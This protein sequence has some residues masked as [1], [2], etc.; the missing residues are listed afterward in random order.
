MLQ[1]EDLKKILNQII[2]SR[3]GRDLEDILKD[4]LEYPLYAITVIGRFYFAEYLYNLIKF[5]KAIDKDSLDLWVKYFTPT[6]FMLGNPIRVAER[7]D[8]ITMYNAKN[9]CFLGPKP[10][11]SLYEIRRL[12]K[13]VKSDFRF[14]RFLPGKD[15]VWTVGRREVRLYKPNEEQKVKKIF[16]FDVNQ[17]SLERGVV[18]ISH[19]LIESLYLSNILIG[20]KIRFIFVDGKID[21]DCDYDYIRINLDETGDKDDLRIYSLTG[22][23]YTGHKV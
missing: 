17:L 1:Q 4:G 19:S 23:P 3:L 14:K 2:N 7:Y 10:K 5:Y 16:Y 22:T 8:D 15:L 6:I 13:L 20:E 11:E 18:H 12:L 9:V 21:S